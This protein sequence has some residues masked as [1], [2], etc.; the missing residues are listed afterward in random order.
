[1]PVDS[2]PRKPVAA[3]RYATFVCE[4]A[5]SIEIFICLPGSAS[6]ATDFF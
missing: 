6:D 1:V 2:K 4:T 3:V 5:P